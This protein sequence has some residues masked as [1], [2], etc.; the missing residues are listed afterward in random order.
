M[1]IRLL[2][3]K[4]TTRI[5]EPKKF[6]ARVANLAG[7][8]SEENDSHSIKYYLFQQHRQHPGLQMLKSFT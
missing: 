2:K 3:Q 7:G 5:T 4:V 1:H 6:Y 8:A